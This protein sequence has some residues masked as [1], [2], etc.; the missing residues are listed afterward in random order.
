MI[1]VNTNCGQYGTGITAENI[2][3]KGQLIFKISDFIVIDHPTYQT[4]QIGPTEHILDNGIIVC[5]NH[6]CEPNIFVNTMDL[7]VRALRDIAPEEELTFF[8]PS[9]EWEMARPFNCMCQAPN[10][11]KYVA[12]AKCL[13]AEILLQY[14]I[15]RHIQDMAGLNIYNRELG[16]SDN[17]TSLQFQSPHNRPI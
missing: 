16:D 14:Q 15:N 11:L 12:G 9:T 6:S 2:I 5:L 7:T 8:Y 3:K 1:K 17:K 13:P 4:I 10:C